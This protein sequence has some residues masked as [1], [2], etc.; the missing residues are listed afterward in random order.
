[1]VTD[2]K[3][4]EEKREHRINLI[5]QVEMSMGSA[6]DVPVYTVARFKK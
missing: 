2:Q 1:M 4:R 5:S 6:A 3:E